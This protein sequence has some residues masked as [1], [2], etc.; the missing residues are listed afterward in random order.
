MAVSKQISSP[1]T[2]T[3][4][5][6]I[7]ISR[8]FDAPREVVWEVFTDPKQVVRWWGPNGFSTTIH[9]MD[10]RPGGVW[11]HTMHGPDGTDYPN[12]SLFIEIVKPQ[13]IKYSHAGGKQGG[14]GMS[15]DVMWT[16]EAQ[17]SKTLLTGR[18]A[19][20]SPEMRDFVAKE[21]GAVEGGKQTMA[22]LAQYLQNAPGRAET[23][24]FVISRTFDTPRE[25]VWKAFTEPERM[26]QWWG[27]KGCKVVFAKMDL[28]PGGTYHYCMQTPDGHQMWGKFV[29]REIVPPERLVFVNSF[30]DKDG[31]LTRHPLSPTWPLEMLSTLTLAENAGK[32]TLTIRWSPLNASEEERNTF[33]SG[34][35]SMQQGWG[36]TLDQLASYL[37]TA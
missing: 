7:I 28:R 22:R 35:A 8:L 29:Y 3:A 16:F 11:R 1:A 33:A 18:I 36:G 23:A 5:R 26:E 32:T 20:P 31:N 14:P 24:D 2:S 6:E 34:H 21:F 25:L 30:S 4:D 10:F 15:S 12:K 37:A 9:E 19:F 17:G 27:P 13:R